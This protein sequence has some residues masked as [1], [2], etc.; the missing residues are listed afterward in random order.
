[1]QVLGTDGLAQPVVVGEVAGL[2][3]PA[4][5]AM[6]YVVAAPAARRRA[7]AAALRLGLRPAGAFLHLPD[8][9]R[10]A[11]IAALDGAAAF[12]LGGMLERGGAKRRL[13]RGLLRVPG[14]VAAAER[15]LPNVGLAF[16]EDGTRAG[17]WLGEGSPLVTQSWRADASVVVLLVRNGAVARVVK[18]HP[19][20][21]ALEPEA[22]A[23]RALAPVAAEAGA[24][25]PELVS[26]DG[27]TL[28]QSGVPGRAARSVLH[29]DPAALRTTLTELA[30]WLERWGS[31]TRRGKAA[32][33]PGA[34]RNHPP[35][36]PPP[37]RRGP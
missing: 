6:V 11:A 35:Q 12:L 26:Y 22:A 15:V 2:S 4:P 7:R 3:A 17:A 24:A 10:S 36:A 34:P 16:T 28:V 5:G 14:G 25:V 31:A 37:P 32:G 23:L 20:I 8:V 19:E 29:A 27:R 1:M 18:V 13:V 9:E 21:A 30:A 33:G